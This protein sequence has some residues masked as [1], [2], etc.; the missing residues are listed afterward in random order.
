MKGSDRDGVGVR[1]QRCPLPFLH[2]AIEPAHVAHRMVEICKDF[3]EA[4]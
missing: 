3:G 2:G 1:A 4:S